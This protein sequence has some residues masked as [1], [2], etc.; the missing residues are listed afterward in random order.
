LL[1]MIIIHYGPYLYMP[2]YVTAPF[3][4]LLYQQFYFI[5]TNLSRENLSIAT[6]VL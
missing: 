6:P 5:F 4:I 1:L 2:S 3:C